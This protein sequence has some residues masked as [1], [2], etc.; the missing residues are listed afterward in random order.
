MLVAARDIQP[1][2]T[3]FSIS[4]S[5]LLHQTIKKPIIRAAVDGLEPWIQLALYAM[6]LQHANADCNSI[7]AT[8]PTHDRNPLLWTVSQLQLLQGTQLLKEIQDQK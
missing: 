4:N 2:D 6:H 7:L 8:L 5:Q 3:L 1:G